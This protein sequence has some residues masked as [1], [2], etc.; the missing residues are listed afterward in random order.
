MQ[1]IKRPNE[2]GSL[3][4]QL[5]STIFLFTGQF[6]FFLHPL[7]YTCI[8]GIDMF[9]S[10]APPVKPVKPAL[11]ATSHLSSVSR[12]SRTT[13]V[14]AGSA[15]G[16]V[17]ASEEKGVERPSSIC[18]FRGSEGAGASSAI[19]SST[20]S[21]AAFTSPQITCLERFSKVDIKHV[22]PSFGKSFATTRYRAEGIFRGTI[23]CFF[24]PRARPPLSKL[25]ICKSTQRR[26]CLDSLW[27]T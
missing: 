25:W 5:S 21:G 8:D 4:N 16:S 24:L 2:P 15:S 14:G 18:R 3:D 1:I 11:A 6:I 20:L 23:F 17:L 7:L 19:S 12:S 27:S 9:P 13:G 22:K 10:S 26:I